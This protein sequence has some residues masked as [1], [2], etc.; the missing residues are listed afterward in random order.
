M[1]WSPSAVSV[2]KRYN[3]PRRRKEGYAILELLR[4][5]KAFDRHNDHPL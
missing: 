4:K 1:V 5:I 2:T 3:G